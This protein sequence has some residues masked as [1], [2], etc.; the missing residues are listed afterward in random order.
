MIILPLSFI[1]TQKKTPLSSRNTHIPYFSGFLFHAA[2]P[3]SAAAALYVTGSHRIAFIT[4]QL[5]AVIMLSQN[6]N[7]THAGLF[8]ISP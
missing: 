8:V 4:W 7:I 6:E 5:S 2:L 1:T 3:D